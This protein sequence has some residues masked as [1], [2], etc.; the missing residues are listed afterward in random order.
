MAKAAIEL[1]YIAADEAGRAR[2][3][4]KLA[5]MMERAAQPHD[6]DIPVSAAVGFRRTRDVWRA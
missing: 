3:L 4:L 6:T 2:G 5:T 1:R